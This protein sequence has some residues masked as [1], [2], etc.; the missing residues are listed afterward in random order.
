MADPWDVDSPKAPIPAAAGGDPWASMSVQGEPNAAL[1][2]V[3]QAQ[4][5]STYAAAVPHVQAL[6]GKERTFDFS[7]IWIVNFDT[8]LAR[9]CACW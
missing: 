4:T 1:A 5:V 7:H 3:D 9:I 8:V 2:G 6:Q